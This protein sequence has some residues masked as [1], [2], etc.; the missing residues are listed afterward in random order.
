MDSTPNWAERRDVALLELAE[1]GMALAR[2]L[3]GRAKGAASALEA[4]RLAHAFDR[5]SRTVRLTFALQSR[6]EREAL[7]VRREARGDHAKQA[8]LRHSQ[9]RAAVR[10]DITAEASDREHERLLLRELDHTLEEAILYEDFATG[11][12][13]AV[14]NRIRK[15]LG[16][17][18]EEA[19]NDPAPNLSGKAAAATGPP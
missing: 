14:I 17:P 12:L 13:A 18:P 16:L 19:A 2:E 3:A 10:R 11:P 9:V 1:L 5:I 6:L 4:E 8:E 7:Q 15:G